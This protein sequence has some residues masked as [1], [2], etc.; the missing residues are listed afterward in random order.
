[1]L[2]TVLMVFA[3]PSNGQ[4]NTVLLGLLTMLKEGDFG[5]LENVFRARQD[6]YFGDEANADEFRVRFMYGIFEAHE[7]EITRQLDHW[8]DAHPASPFALIARGWHHFY[9]G[10]Q[11]R[12]GAWAKDTPR[13]KFEQMATHFRRAQA[14]FNRA[15][16]IEP[17]SI[18]AYTGLVEIARMNGT[19]ASA[20]RWFNQGLELLPHSEALRFAAFQALEPNWGGNMGAINRFAALTIEQTDNSPRFQWVKG[21]KDYVI[22]RAY[23][24]AGRAKEALAHIDKAVSVAGAGW[25]R[26]ERSYINTALGDYEAATKDA[27]TFLHYVPRD[28]SATWQLAWIYRKREMFDLALIHYDRAVGM[29]AHHPKLL[30]ER[31]SFLWQLQR[32]ENALAD[33]ALALTYAPTD[34][35]LWHTQG[36]WLDA[37]KRHAEAVPSYREALR[38]AGMSRALLKS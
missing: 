21:Y 26:L 22:A 30:V 31:A 27:K 5:S 12:G 8:V 25:Y 1:M 37:K 10:T 20:G 29:K 6:E 4:R 24:F 18:G 2:A 35:N 16:V 38:L 19:M 9:L 23:R 15:I 33:I 11:A 13:Q 17:K 34:A 36:H 32:R 14:D 28:F 3:L 7:R